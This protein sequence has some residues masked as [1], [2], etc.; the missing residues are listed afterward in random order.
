MS[1]EKP[2]HEEPSKPDADLSYEDAM[3]ARI[4]RLANKAQST[5]RRSLL[6]SIGSFF[7]LALFTAAA[8]LLMR[9]CR[10]GKRFQDSWLGTERK[11][12]TGG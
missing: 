6:I 1:K 3:Q 2:P 4:N 9:G 5:R 8:L 10:G 12:R 11:R 7:V